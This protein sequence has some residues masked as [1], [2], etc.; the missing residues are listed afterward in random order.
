[1]SNIEIKGERVKA[2]TGIL[3]SRLSKVLLRNE[4]SGFEFASGIPGS[5]G[6]AVTM[7]AGAYGEK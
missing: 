6:G 1:M 2:Q 4:L 7:N 5:L 3:L